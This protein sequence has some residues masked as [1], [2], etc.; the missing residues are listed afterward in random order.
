MTLTLGPRK[1]P[2]RKVEFLLR[3]SEWVYTLRQVTHNLPHRQTYIQ[4]NPGV[5]TNDP[6]GTLLQELTDRQMGTLY[7]KT[8]L[9]SYRKK[10]QHGPQ[11]VN[12]FKSFCRT[13][14]SLLWH[15]QLEATN[16]MYLYTSLGIFW[17]EICI[18]F[19]PSSKHMLLERAAHVWKPR[20]TTC[21]RKNLFGRS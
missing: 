21:S 18:F 16:L 2:R 14:F 11:L 9:S 1:N 6:R 13:H 3:L 12:M 20:R 7:L 8:A 5:H 15:C 17:Q 19:T 4:M 10:Y